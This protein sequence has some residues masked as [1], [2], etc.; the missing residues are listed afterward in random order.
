MSEVGL[1]LAVLKLLPKY[2]S[3]PEAQTMAADIVRML[4]GYGIERLADDLGYRVEWD[5]MDGARCLLVWD[6]CSAD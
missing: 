4:R 2:M 3:F 5:V 6:D 1:Q